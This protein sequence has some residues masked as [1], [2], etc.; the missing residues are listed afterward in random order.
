VQVVLTEEGKKRLE[1]LGREFE[2]LAAQA[3]EHVPEERLGIIVES[4]QEITKT[5]KT[6]LGGEEHD[7]F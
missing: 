2:S 5:L 6:Y 7:K 3:F 1:K 4:V